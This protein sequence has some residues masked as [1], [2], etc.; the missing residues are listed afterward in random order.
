MVAIV[1]EV[2]TWFTCACDHFKGVIKTLGNNVFENNIACV[3]ECIQ[4]YYVHFINN[5]IYYAIIL[6]IR[7]QRPNY[8]RI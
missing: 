4:Y 5:K 1:H 3:Y 8:I 6:V 7:S 2:H